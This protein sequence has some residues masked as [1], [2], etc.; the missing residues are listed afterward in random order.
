LIDAVL[1]EQKPMRERAR[2][3][4]ENPDLVRSIVAEGCEKARTIARATLDDVR[5]AMGLDYR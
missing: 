5:E 4:E 2:Q 1:E 3:Y